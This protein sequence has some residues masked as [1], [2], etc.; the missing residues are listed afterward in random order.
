MAHRLVQ[1]DW[2]CC[3]RKV[4]CGSI[5]LKEDWFA[6][7]ELIVSTKGFWR[8]DAE[9]SEPYLAAGMWVSRGTSLASLLGIWTVTISNN[10]ARNRPDLGWRSAA[11]GIRRTGFAHGLDG[12]DSGRDPAAGRPM[13][14]SIGFSCLIRLGDAGLAAREP[15]P[16]LF[17]EERLAIVESVIAPLLPRKRVGRPLLAILRMLLAV[18]YCSVDLHQAWHTGGSEA[19]LA[20]LGEEGI[21]GIARF[22]AF[23]LL[24]LGIKIFWAGRARPTHASP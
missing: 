17:S 13:A 7:I 23:I 5:L 2:A 12:F 16:L 10:S 4:H 3:M 1:W 15:R 18:W 8:S 6:G 9:T 20:R 22:P 24:R 11:R 19:R 21:G 14:F